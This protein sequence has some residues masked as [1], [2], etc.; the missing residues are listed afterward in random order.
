MLE[1]IVGVTLT[2]LLGGFLV[3]IVKGLL[4]RRTERYSSSV[5]L[6]DTLAESLW[7]YWHIAV[8]VAYY[9][10][11]G[12]RGAESLDL[13]LRHFDSDESWQIGV[14]VQTQLSRSKRFL[15][16]PAQEQLV[17]AQQQVIEHLDSEVDRLRRGATS[18]DWSKFYETLMT[19]TR[20]AID[21]LLNGL[22]SDLK[23]GRSGTSFQ[24]PNDGAGPAQS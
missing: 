22:I 24:Q 21:S 15:P 13:A 12:E 3:P 8:R 7:K 10:R 2:A 11:Q 6:V 23:I 20:P 17:K 9:G 14:D 18:D 19:R 4:D 5:A 1:V 16:A